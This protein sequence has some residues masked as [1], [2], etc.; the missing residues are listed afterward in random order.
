VGPFAAE[1]VRKTVT[2]C[3]FSIEERVAQEQRFH[4]T[5]GATAVVGEAGSRDPVA[6][7]LVVD[8]GLLSKLPLPEYW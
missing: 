8:G 6:T 5:A 4:A 3:L 2:F 1:T 7:L